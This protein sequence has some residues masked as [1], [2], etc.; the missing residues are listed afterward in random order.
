MKARLSIAVI[1]VL[2]FYSCAGKQDAPPRDPFKKIV[3]FGPDTYSLSLAS[4]RG[5]ANSRTVALRT[6]NEFCKSKDKE[7]MPVSDKTGGVSYTILFRCLNADDPE[8][9]R[10]DWDLGPS[11]KNKEVDEKKQ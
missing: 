6:V 8:L 11:G 10:Q 9:I 1:F 3:S 4:T 2:L 5:S 7:F